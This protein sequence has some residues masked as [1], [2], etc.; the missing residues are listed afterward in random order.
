MVS[1]R[2][3]VGGG[4]RKEGPTVL[5][6]LST[7]GGH[8]PLL[9]GLRRLLVTLSRGIFIEGGGQNLTGMSHGR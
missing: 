2:P 3:S 6:L 5:M 1:G 9:W 8:P 4:F 7:P